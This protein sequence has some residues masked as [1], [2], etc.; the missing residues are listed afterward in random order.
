M[1]HKRYEIGSK[2]YVSPRRYKSQALFAAI[3]YST[4]HSKAQR[5]VLIEL[6][7]QGEKSRICKSLE[8]RGEREVE[9]KMKLREKNRKKETKIQRKARKKNKKTQK[10]EGKKEGEYKS[11]VE[12]IEQKVNEESKE[13]NRK[14][15]QKERKKELT[16]KVKKRKASECG[17]CHQPGHNAR[18]CKSDNVSTCLQK[19]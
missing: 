13:I 3:S 14:E 5:E 19:Q 16:N 7:N 4:G 15:V 8:K 10:K 18:T 11:E 12:V 17:L 2:N 9:R 1:F 6:L